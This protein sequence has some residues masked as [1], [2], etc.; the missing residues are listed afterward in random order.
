M[1]IKTELDQ[2]RHK[3][4]GRTEEDGEVVHVCVFV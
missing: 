4:D 3:E 1:L 2:D